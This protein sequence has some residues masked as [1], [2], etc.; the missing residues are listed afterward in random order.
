MHL[1]IA[2]RLGASLAS[3]DRV[4]AES[5]RRLGVEVVDA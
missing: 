5:A 1:M 3:F 2:R 4:M